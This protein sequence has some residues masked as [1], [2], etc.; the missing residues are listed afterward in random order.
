MRPRNVPEV[1]RTRALALGAADWLDE[2]P[3][4]VETIEAEWSISVGRPL[5]GGSEA[6]VAEAT[7]EDGTDAI[8][9]LLTEA[10]SSK[11]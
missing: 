8:V 5:S 7:L 3:S 6:F 4:L 2:L 11:E 1:V 10:V 9:K